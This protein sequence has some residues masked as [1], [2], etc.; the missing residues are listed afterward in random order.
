MKAIT[1]ATI[2]GLLLTLGFL[3]ALHVQFAFAAPLIESLVNPDFDIQSGNSSGS[4]VC[5]PICHVSSNN[6]SSNGGS[7]VTD[8]QPAYRLTVNVPSHPFGTSTV[9][10]SLTTANGHTDEANVPT[11]GGLSYTFNIP[12]NQGK[13]VQVCVKPGNLSIKNCRTY[14]STGSDMSVSLP[15][16]SSTSSSSNYHHIGPWRGWGGYGPYFPG[17]D[18]P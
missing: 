16:V 6:G 15:A 7:S 14:E 12:E 9:D 17:Y 13:S 5:D 11:A 18:Y 2:L 3:T 4:I 10:I 8:A 1:A